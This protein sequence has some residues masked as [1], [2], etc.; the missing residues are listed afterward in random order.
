MYICNVLTLEKWSVGRRLLRLISIPL[1]PFV[2]A[3]KN[4][5]HAKANALDLK[6]FF[7][8]LP[9]VL[10]LHTGSAA[11][12]AAGLLFGF[13]DREYRFAEFETSARRPD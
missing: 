8:D 3:Y 11:G 5:K 9:A 4:Y 6:Q 2:R 12:I 7:V 13:Q 10:L 1:V